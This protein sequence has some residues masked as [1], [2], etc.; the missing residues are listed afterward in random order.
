MTSADGAIAPVIELLRTGPSRDWRKATFS[1]SRKADWDRIMAEAVALKSGPAMKVVT[2]DS[3]GQRTQTYSPSDWPNALND[4]LG[5]DPRTIHVAAADGDWHARRGKRRWLV[6]LGRSSQEADLAA[7]AKDLPAHDKV[8]SSLLDPS[9]ASVQA[10]F[11]ETGLISQKG[12]ILNEAAG[13]F[14]QVRHFL[15]ALRPLAIL[16]PEPGRPL[17]V[18]DAGCGSAHLGLALY[19]HAS[20][21]GLTPSLTAVDRNEVLVERVSTIAE[22]LHYPRTQI[23]AMAVA[24]LEPEDLGQVDLVF[25]LHL[26]DTATDDA[27]VAGIRLGAPAIVLAPCCQ[28]ELIRQLK[29]Q[30]LSDAEAAFA[31]HG[32]MRERLASVLTDELRVLVLEAAGYRVELIDFT[33]PKNTGKTL[34]V[35]AERRGRGVARPRREAARGRFTAICDRWSIEPSCARALL[36]TD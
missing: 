19:L 36:E 17:H 7:R 18:V 13:K 26:C 21:L 27:L 3:A 24:D 32:A 1:N 15:E 34:M 14:R 9:D 31:R 5:G 30:Q 4:I 23:R 12:Q 16:Q 6:S 29:P 22:R 35:R 8:P 20:E 11:R 33:D 28:H 2:T 10:L 25:A